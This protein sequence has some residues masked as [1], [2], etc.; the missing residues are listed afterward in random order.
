[1][2]TGLRCLFFLVTI[3]VQGVHSEP[4]HL[5][6]PRSLQWDQFLG[7]NAH[8]LWFTPTQYQLQIEKLRALGLVWTRVDLHWD[9]LEPKENEFDYTQLDDV[10]EALAKSHLKSVIYLVGSAP[11]ASSAPR[12]AK[13]RDTYPPENPTLFAARLA[14]LAQRYPSVDAWQIW[15]E[16]NLPTFWQSNQ[17]SE[18]YAELLN[19]SVQ[20]LRR[21]DP[22]T[23]VVMAGMAYFSQIPGHQTLM[24]EELAGL[25]IQ[26]LGTLIAYHPY[27]LMPEGDQPETKDF[28]L[29]TRQLNQQ[30]RQLAPPAIWATEWGWSSYPGPK[31]EQPIIG[32]EGQ[33][34]FVLRRL[35]LMSG[36]DFDRVF[37]FSLSDLDER[38]TPRDRYYGLLDVNGHP[39]PV[40]HALANFLKITGPRLWPGKAPTIAPCPSDL[41]SVSWVREDGTQ[42]LLFWADGEGEIRLPDIHAG[43]LYDPLAGTAQ[44]LSQTGG[45]KVPVR[46]QLQILAW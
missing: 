32:E 21:V 27:S 20:S 6:P 22:E 13:A 44:G 30:L 10:I 23:P 4:L 24:L 40:Y 8:F 25:G 31:V 11:W 15:N 14:R 34:D 29:R 46:Q 39:K 16:P 28:I 45:L 9:H 2:S 12:W 36:L 38:A 3:A 26:R 37:L 7:V 42:L 33:A 35:A 43:M 5:T 19:V 17:A 18:A 1:M 41:V